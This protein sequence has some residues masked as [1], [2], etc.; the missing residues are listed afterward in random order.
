MKEIQRSNEDF[1]IHY[2]KYGDP[3]FPPAWMT[4]EVVSMGTLS[5]LFYALSDTNPS[6]I[7]I[8]KGFGLKKVYILKNWMH[9]LSTFRNICAHHSRVWNRRFTISLKL[10]YNTD[11]PFLSKEEAKKIRNNKLFSYLSI[12]L[13][14]LQIISPDSSFK[15][16][17]LSLVKN[18]PKLVELKDMGFPN[19]W[20]DFTLWE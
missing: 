2:N 18:R 4:L 14:L 3:E 9:A 7:A 15:D 17:L 19:Q 20:Q 11:A 12:I 10:P 8:T 6:S 5:K 13:Y 1:I 16:N